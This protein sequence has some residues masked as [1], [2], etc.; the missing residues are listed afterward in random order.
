MV[1][2]FEKWANTFTADCRKL[3]EGT[4]LDWAN[5]QMIKVEAL[6][7]RSKQKLQCMSIGKQLQASGKQFCCKN[8]FSRDFD[9]QENV[10][11]NLQF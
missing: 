5:K 7:E 4:Q 3:D 9:G 6:G 11:Q 1:K 8:Q 2:G 10:G